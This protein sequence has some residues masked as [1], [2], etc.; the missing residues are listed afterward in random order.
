MQRLWL[1]MIVG[2]VAAGC[3]PAPP[4]GIPP[5]PA[6][7]EPPG[8]P[9]Q[10]Y[11]AGYAEGGQVYRVVPRESGVRIR[12]YPAGPLADERGH[13]HVAASRKVQGYV[14]VAD[15]AEGSRADLFLPVHSLQVDRPE[16]LSAIGW[17]SELTP[18]QKRA[19]R[20]NMLGPVLKAGTYPFVEISVR[21]RKA[22]LPAAT[23]E[24]RITLRGVEQALRSKAA[25]QLDRDR[26]R[27]V[28]AFRL[29]QTAFG[30]EPFSAMGGLLT[31]RDTIEVSYRVVAAPLS[32]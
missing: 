29:Q 15:E 20:R 24:S 5:R 11:E 23:L 16:D 30:I 8:F 10:R 22:D 14:F 7:N 31:V 6:V 9:S 12:V 1:W 3:A 26:L 25:V 28:G 13:K 4:P 2:L 21:A 27:A 32:D 19:T 17:H 18:A